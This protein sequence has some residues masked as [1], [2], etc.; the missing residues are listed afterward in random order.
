MSLPDISIPQARR[1]AVD[2]T[3]AQIVQ[4]ESPAVSLV[5]RTRMRPRMAGGGWDRDIGAASAML[6]NPEIAS[7]LVYERR[8]QAADG[9]CSVVQ[10][11]W[12][13]LCLCVQSPSRSH[14]LQR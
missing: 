6:G 5:M 3:G 8:L 1:I 13:Y 14:C 2:T 11:L 4:E 9:R 10:L 7:V 12:S